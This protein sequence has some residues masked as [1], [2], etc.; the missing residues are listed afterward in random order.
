M[1]DKTFKI[2]DGLAVNG[3]LLVAVNGTIGVNTATPNATFHIVA[4][5]GIIVPSGTTAQRPNNNV[6]AFRYNSDLGKFEGYTGSTWAGFGAAAS[7]GAN[8]QVLFNDSGA[9]GASAGFV[10]DKTTNNAF[11]SNALSLAIVSSGN[12]TANLFANST[13]LT[14]ANTTSTTIISSLGVQVGSNTV[15]N[16]IMTFVGNSTINSFM[17]SSSLSIQGVSANGIGTSNN[18]LLKLDASGNAPSVN[19]LAQT[20]TDGATVNWNMASGVIATLTLTGNSHAIAAP[21]PMRVGSAILHVFQDTT[22][23]RVVT[24]NAVFK[25]PGGVA[26]VLSPGANKHDI[27]SFVCDGSSLFGTYMND[28]R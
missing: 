3:A 26:P 6:G 23:G 25:W 16:S 8:T 17:N 7:P 19:V 1:V 18:N 12:T 27:F 28:V 4:T 2:V 13:T 24:W 15:V 22:A 5:D 14:I 21:S 11:L 9:E 20:L 10:F